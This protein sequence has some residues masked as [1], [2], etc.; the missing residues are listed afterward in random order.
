MNVREGTKGGLS[1]RGKG[2]GRQGQHARAGAGEARVEGGEDSGR[3]V[4][5]QTRQGARDGRGFVTD[6]GEEG[7]SV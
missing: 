2:P 7:A 1:W 3:L 4:W 6:D 5:P